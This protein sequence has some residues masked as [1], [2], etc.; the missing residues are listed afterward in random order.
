MKYAN[1]DAFIAK[2]G[3]ELVGWTEATGVCPIERLNMAPQLR[4][5]ITALNTGTC[6]WEQLSA[7]EWAIR[8][9]EYKACVDAGTVRQHATRKDK[10]ISRKGKQ[11]TSNEIINEGSD[12]SSDKENVDTAVM[13]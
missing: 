8:K 1:Y 2:W 3:V 7:D 6:H 10:G 12:D 13:A 4:H 9:A 11:P 5:L